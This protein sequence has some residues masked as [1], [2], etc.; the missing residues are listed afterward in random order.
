M[1][2]SK[3]RSLRQGRSKGQIRKIFKDFCE[4]TSL[5][6]YSYLYTTQTSGMKLAW[7]FMILVMSGLGFSFL[8]SNT[9]AY[10]KARLVTTIESSTADL[11][12][13]NSDTHLP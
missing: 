11:S 5:H 2:D 8:A 4:S 9:K 13:S 1:L 10:F 3:S 12:V 6:G 7:M